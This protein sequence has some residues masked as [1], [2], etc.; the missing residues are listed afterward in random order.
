MKS[1]N[2]LLGEFVAAPGDHTGIR[3]HVMQHYSDSEG[4]VA[5]NRLGFESQLSELGRVPQLLPT[6]APLRRN[7][8]DG[9]E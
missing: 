9:T 6:A 1:G 7:G 2:R 3:S 4:T 5:Q 8:G